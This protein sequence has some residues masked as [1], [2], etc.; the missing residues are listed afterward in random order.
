VTRSISHHRLHLDNVTACAVSSTNVQATILALEASLEQAQ[1]CETLLF[2]DADLSALR[3]DVSPQIRLV[4]ISKIS[5]SQ[6]YSDFVLNRLVEHIRSD[7]CLIMQW[8][9]HVLDATRWSPEF[10]EYD[11]IGA[12]WPQFVDGYT[13]GN[14]GFSLRSRR[15]MEACRQPQFE[16]HHPEDLAICRTNR[17]WLEDCGMRFAPVELADAFAAERAG[18]PACSFGYHGVFLMP[19]VLGIERFWEIY[20]TLDERT[21]VRQDLSG[22]FNAVLRGQKPVSR[23]LVLIGRHLGD[24]ADVRRS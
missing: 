2:T 13:V 12:S 9:G 20:L 23:A 16:A 5:S 22:L 3:I 11:Y 15:L 21:A 18:D 24:I 14:G 19:Q 6:E 1:F 4:P 7:Y 8:D 17:A 10:L